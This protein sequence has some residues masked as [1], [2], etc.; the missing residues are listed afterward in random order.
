[1]EV[2]SIGLRGGAQ[3]RHRTIVQEDSDEDIPDEPNG[4]NAHIRTHNPARTAC[5]TQ[6]NAEEISGF[7]N[8]GRTMKRCNTS[9][10]VW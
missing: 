7:T 4:R 9:K 1:L 5:N 2:N 8:S 10:Y 3:G 6:K